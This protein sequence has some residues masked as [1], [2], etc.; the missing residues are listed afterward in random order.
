MIQ[1]LFLSVSAGF[2]QLTDRHN[3]VEL[4][5]SSVENSGYIKLTGSDEKFNEHVMES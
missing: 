2:L 3:S 5:G 4:D 1:L